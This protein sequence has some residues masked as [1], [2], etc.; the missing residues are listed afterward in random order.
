[1]SLPHFSEET[2]RNLL[3]RV[4]SVTGRELPDWFKEID[5]GPCFSRFED[6]V[7]WLQDEHSIAHGHAT[8][9]M[10]EHDRRRMSRGVR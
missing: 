3:A 4:P 7:H 6:R 8:A 10:R 5:Q 2:H 9:I 1:M